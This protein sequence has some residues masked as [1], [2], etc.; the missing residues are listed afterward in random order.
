MY[1]VQT[2]SDPPPPPLKFGPKMD[3]L[4]KVFFGVTQSG[5]FVRLIP[6]EHPVPPHLEQYTHYNWFLL[7][8]NNNLNNFHYCQN[9]I[10]KSLDLGSDPLPPLWTKYILSFFFFNDDLPYFIVSNPLSFVINFKIWQTPSTPS[11]PP[12]PHSGLNYYI[13]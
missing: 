4:G 3:S 9:D 12:S 6:L 8:S 11:R 5:Y 7:L 10:Q 2:L 13:M 1:F